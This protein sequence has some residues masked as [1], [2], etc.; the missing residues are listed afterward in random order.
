MCQLVRMVY[1]YVCSVTLLVVTCRQALTSKDVRDIATA[2]KADGSLDLKTHCLSLFVCKPSR[3]LHLYV[4]QH[5]GDIQP[6]MEISI[7]P[8]AESAGASSGLGIQAH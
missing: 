1:M 4:H 7:Q 5:H 6:S 2:A 3:G 8:C